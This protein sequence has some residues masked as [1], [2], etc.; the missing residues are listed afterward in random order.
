MAS[1]SEQWC[2][3][4]FSFLFILNGVL[5]LPATGVMPDC[6][7][8]DQASAL[9]ATL[10]SKDYNQP[11]NSLLGVLLYQVIFALSVAS[12]TPTNQHIH[13]MHA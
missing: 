11:T 2:P 3:I 8:G 9:Q 6:R 4:C 1:H 7:T 5:D 13:G 10:H 12:T